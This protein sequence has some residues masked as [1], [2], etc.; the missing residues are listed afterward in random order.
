MSV[1]PQNPTWPEYLQGGTLGDGYRL[2]L[3]AKLFQQY[4][5][6][7]RY[8]LQSKV[9]IY[10]WVNYTATK[11]AY[12]SKTDAYRVFAEMLDSGHPPNDWAELL[13][14]ARAIVDRY[15]GIDE[16]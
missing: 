9:I 7:F 4:R 3:R 10:S 15:K 13:L 6:F 11:R 2:W 12:D 5:L 16:L 14:E 1:I 8:H